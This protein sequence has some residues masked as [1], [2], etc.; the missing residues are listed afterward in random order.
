MDNLWIIP[1]MVFELFH[2][3]DSIA[4]LGSSFMASWKELQNAESLAWLRSQTP[5]WPQHV[6]G[7]S[8]EGPVLRC[9]TPGFSHTKDDG[10][11]CLEENTLTT[12][13]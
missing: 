9:G 13:L 4:V 2:W 6:P 1:W 12:R 7:C 3:W 5:R 11:G 10:N 8:A